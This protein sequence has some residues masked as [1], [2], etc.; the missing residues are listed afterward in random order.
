MT[1]PVLEV[2][3]PDQLSKLCQCCL[4]PAWKKIIFGWKDAHGGQATSIALCRGHI[5]ELRRELPGRMAP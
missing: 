4:A 1:Q 3:K 5:D 2:K